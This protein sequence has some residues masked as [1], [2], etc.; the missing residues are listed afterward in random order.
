ME[1]I[2]GII[3]SIVTAIGG[4]EAIRYLIN[5][6]A[7]SRKTEA[8]ADSAATSV[9]KEMQ[10]TYHIFI[11]DAKQTLEED[12]KYIG[13]L[14]ADRRRLEVERDELIKRIDQTD[15]RVRDLQMEVARYGRMVVSLRPLMCG[16]L[17][18]RNRKPVEISDIGEINN[19]PN[20]IEPIK[21]EDMI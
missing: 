17:G 11:S 14:K 20:E 15:E 9:I 5:R 13:S 4:W 16:Y 6:K 7:E 10:E 8:E 19:E 12:K 21:Q 2:V 18:C 1:G 3:I